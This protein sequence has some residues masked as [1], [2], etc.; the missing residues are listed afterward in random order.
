MASGLPVPGERH[1]ET[2]RHAAW[3]ERTRVRRGRMRAL[4][5]TRASCH[6]W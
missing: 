1:D 2:V 3:N 4:P 6:R 5:M